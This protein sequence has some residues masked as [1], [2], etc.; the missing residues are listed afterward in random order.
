[1]EILTVPQS[2]RHIQIEQNVYTAAMLVVTIS[3]VV[4]IIFNAFVDAYPTPPA[5][6]QTTPAPTTTVTQPLDYHYDNENF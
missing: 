4:W 5:S 3:L 6:Y 1:M 2:L